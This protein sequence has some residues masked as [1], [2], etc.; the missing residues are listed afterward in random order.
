MATT[1]SEARLDL[2]ISV[3]AKALIE[4]A[5]AAQGRSV[6]DFAKEALTQSAR[7]ALEDGAVVRLSD[8]DR[9][10]FLQM[11][12]ADPVPNAALEQAARR[13]RE[14]VAE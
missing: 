12:D 6:S 4:R 3:E 1:A 2:S 13:H 11:L 9:D 8:R 14:R 5:A 7:A 10:L